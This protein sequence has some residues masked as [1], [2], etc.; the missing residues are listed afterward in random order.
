MKTHYQKLLPSYAALA[1]FGKALE[2]KKL[3][4]EFNKALTKCKR[5]LR[6]K[7]NKLKVRIL[8]ESS[9]L[10]LDKSLEVKTST[11]PDAG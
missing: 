3:Q 6:T 11:I 1:D 10:V 9:P 8:N 4:R 5:Q 7:L 2:D